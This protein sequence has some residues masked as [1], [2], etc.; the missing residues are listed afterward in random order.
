MSPVTF[1]LETVRNSQNWQKI[2]PRSGSAVGPWPTWAAMATARLKPTS[3][4][5]YSP[6]AAN[7]PRLLSDPVTQKY[8]ATQARPNS[9]LI[10]L[11]WQVF[12]T[13]VLCFDF[14]PLLKVLPHICW[15]EEHAVGCVPTM[16]ILPRDVLLCP[17]RLSPLSFWSHSN[18]FTVKLIHKPRLSRSSEVDYFCKHLRS[19]GG[20]C[21][22]LKREH[23]R[24]LWWQL[25]Q[26]DTA[27]GTFFLI[28]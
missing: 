4:S 15:V 16:L 5:F 26:T 11:T 6:P 23:D 28:T 14:F 7:P 13:S 8:G 22:A 24:N 21:S 10:W 18:V 20:F 1:Q 19:L 25:S 3:S 9:G 27:T 17:M 12:H 2:Q